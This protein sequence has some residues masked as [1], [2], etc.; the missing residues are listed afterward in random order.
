MVTCDEK[1][2]QYRAVRNSYSPYTTKI[3]GPFEN[4]AFELATTP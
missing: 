1:Y 2:A 4:P 3:A